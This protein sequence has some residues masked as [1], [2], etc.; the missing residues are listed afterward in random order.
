MALIECSRC[1]KR[2]LYASQ[3]HACSG[4]SS[5]GGGNTSSDTVPSSARKCNANQDLPQTRAERS[6]GEPLGANP[7]AK[8]PEASGHNRL[9]GPQG[10]S[11]RGSS[12]LRAGRTAQD[13]APSSDVGRVAIQTAKRGRPKRTEP[14]PWEAL[15]ISKAN[16]YRRQAKAAKGEM[17]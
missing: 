8:E 17:E 11:H 15:G 5:S 4:K 13:A 7:V 3:S 12:R 14:A 1:K 16:Y 9:G 6:N 2:L 10:T